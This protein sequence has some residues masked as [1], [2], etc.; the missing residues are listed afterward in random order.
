MVAHD[1]EVALFCAGVVFAID[2]GGLEFKVRRGG[3][4]FDV[5]VDWRGNG[6]GGEEG[7]NDQCWIIHDSEDALLLYGSMNW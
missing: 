6:G 3:S 7:G 5:F 2:H 4:G 1:P